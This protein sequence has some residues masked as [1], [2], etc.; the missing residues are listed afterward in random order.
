MFI[1]HCIVYF[2]KIFGQIIDCSI[3]LVGWT[4]LLSG[5]CDW[6]LMLTGHCA[7]LVVFMGLSV[8]VWT[9]LLAGQ[10]YGCLDN[11]V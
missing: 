10:H 2:W 8:V 3:C 4:V 7:L 11:I 9:I 6:T 5:Q 1:Q